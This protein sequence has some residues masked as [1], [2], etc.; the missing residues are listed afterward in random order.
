M[1][2]TE[3]VKTILAIN[4]NNNIVVVLIFVIIKTV[5]SYIIRNKEIEDY[6]RL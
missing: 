5:G 1:W 6:K 2:L 3:E 4:N